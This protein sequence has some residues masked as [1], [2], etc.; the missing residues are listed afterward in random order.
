MTNQSPVDGE[1]AYNGTSLED[2]ID[3][4]V[5]RWHAAPDDGVAIH[6]RLG[7]SPD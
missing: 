7:M 5:R 1:R 4:E 3:L 6:E 2:K